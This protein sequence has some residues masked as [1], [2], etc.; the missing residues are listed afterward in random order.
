MIWV[1]LRV[2]QAATLVEFVCLLPLTIPPIVIVVGISN[3][4]AWVTYIFGDSALT[5]T[6]RVRR[7][8][9]C[10]TPTGPSTRALAAID[11]NTLVGGRAQSS[12]PAGAR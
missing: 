8:W 1:R 9:C 3:V 7:S 4:Y 11:V 12:A 6:L 2:P 5:L 10:P